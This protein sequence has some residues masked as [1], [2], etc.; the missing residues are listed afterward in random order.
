MTLLEKT[1]CVNFVKGGG[2]KLLNS[3][4]RL[5]VPGRFL[6]PPPPFY[7]TTSRLVLPELTLRKPLS[8]PLRAKFPQDEPAHSV[9]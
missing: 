8:D 4:P 9:R 6:A 3:P 2:L 5:G 7:R 1:V